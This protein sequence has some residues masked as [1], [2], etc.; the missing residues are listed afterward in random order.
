MKRLPW[1]KISVGIGISGVLVLFF[2][3]YSFVAIQEL[4]EE[5]LKLN[6]PDETANYYFSKLFAERGE[7][8]YSEP[9]LQDTK[10]LV[11]PRSMTSSSDATRVIPVSFLGMVLLYGFLGKLFG[12]G[13]ILFFTP[14][15]AVGA[16]VCFYFLLTHFFTKRIAFIS[17]LL[18][19]VHPAY[20][21]YSARGMF[22]NVLFI[23]LLIIGLCLLW[24]AFSVRDIKKSAWVF[25]LSGMCT[26][27]AL[28]VRLSEAPWVFLLFLFIWICAIKRFRFF[29]T[30]FFVCGVAVSLAV[31][32][33]YNQ[34]VYGGVF[35][36]GYAVMDAE[37]SIENAQKALS[38][39]LFPFGFVPHIFWQNFLTYGIA[40]FW[41]FTLPASIGGA[42]LFFKG[43]RAIRARTFPKEWGYLFAFLLV[44]AW[45]IPFYGSWVVEDT[46]SGEETLGNSYVRYWLALYCFMIPLAAYGMYHAYTYARSGVGKKIIMPFVC[47]VFLFY[48]LHEVLIQKTDG[49][50]SV[51]GHIQ[52]YRDIS[53]YVTHYTESDAVIFSSRSD[54]IFFPQRRAAQSF[55]R[56]AEADIL[57]ALIQRAPV[58]YYGMG[59]HETALYISKKYFL[60]YG[61]GLEYAHTIPGGEPLYRIISMK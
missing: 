60:P 55:E 21:Y 27:A 2:F 25:I 56:I 20:W 50:L 1:K 59:S 15:I 34:Q 47:F 11:R 13:A 42:H 23:D 10:G 48:S 38:L 37:P 33:Y 36:S 35:S 9:L 16:S 19:L 39:V 26:G 54:K 44:S 6:S 61:V 24:K 52:E 51:V 58:Y 18:L 22:P 14:A 45:L 30:L 3:L 17:A 29:G 43:M 28:T 41:W 12:W 46:I 4:A 57:P 32:L 7:I 49:L 40:M 31:L 8:G 53:K 5:P